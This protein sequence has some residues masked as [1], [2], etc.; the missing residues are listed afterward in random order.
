MNFYQLNGQ[1]ALK[2]FHRHGIKHD[3]M[4][5]EGFIRNAEWFVCGGKNIVGFCSIVTSRTGEES[6]LDNLWIDDKYRKQ[7]FGSELITYVRK[8]VNGRILV[9]ADSSTVKFWKKNGKVTKE[10]FE[11]TL[12]E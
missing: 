3:I 7:G 11:I 10:Y 4:V 12:K 8:N 6:I 2:L 9:I 5:Y 1:K